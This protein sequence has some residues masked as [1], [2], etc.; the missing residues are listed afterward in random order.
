MDKLCGYHPVP[1]VC[2]RG[3]NRSRKGA[4]AALDVAPCARDTIRFSHDCLHRPP[5]RHGNGRMS[6]Y[7]I[8]LS[9]GG[10][11]ERTVMQQN[12]AAA[13]NLGAGHGPDDGVSGQRRLQRFRF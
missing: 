5:K 3:G 9:G 12:V 6:E 11:G 10:G 2:R 7:R 4:H 1:F 8:K 13:G